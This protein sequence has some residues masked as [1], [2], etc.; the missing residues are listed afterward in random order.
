MTDVFQHLATHMQTGARGVIGSVAQWYS[1]YLAHANN[2]L[3]GKL[4]PQAAEF[5]ATYVAKRIEEP[6]RDWYSKDIAEETS[7]L[8]TSLGN[9]RAPVEN[10]ELKEIERS[11]DWAI[12][13][14]KRSLMTAFRDKTNLLADCIRT[15]I[16]DALVGRDKS[17]NPWHGEGGLKPDID[18]NPPGSQG[19]EGR[20]RNTAARTPR[21][22]ICGKT[23]AN[24]PIE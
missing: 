19:N 6:V 17:A 2:T 9:L 10:P 7:E 13:N 16:H 15:R 4:L 18:M 14:S 3:N 24:R 11:V 8:I 20:S 12:F 5:I 21:F 22:P 1:A 23:S